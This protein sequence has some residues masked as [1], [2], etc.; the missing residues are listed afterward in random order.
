MSSEFVPIPA[1]A[2]SVRV[3]I[4][5]AQ[6]SF[7]ELLRT[8]LESEP[9]VQVVGDASDTRAAHALARRFRPDVVLIECS[10]NREFSA[11][12]SAEGRNRKYASGTIVI[13]ET[14]RVKDIVESFEL[15]ARGVV[16]KSSLP[17]AWMPGIQT[18]LAGQYWVEHRS[19]A[20]L[21][22]ALRNH[23]GEPEIKSLPD[24]GL[25]LRETE[26]AGKIAAGRSNKEVSREFS[27]C[28]RTVKHHLTNIFKKVGVSSRL[29]LAVLVR[30]GLPSRLQPQSAPQSQKSLEKRN[31]YLV[32]EP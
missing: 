26:I 17:L 9:R 6:S 10:L 31:L 16:L 20:I 24:F 21:L 32:S 15:G 28:E 22:D 25:T 1:D 13:I 12:C 29:E 27:I 18:I 8:Q 11:L 14:P 30:D 7:R 19:V 5:A 3:V 23:P 4:A 2:R